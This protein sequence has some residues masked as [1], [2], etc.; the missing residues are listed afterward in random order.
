MDQPK[1][2]KSIKKINLGDAGGQAI[3]YN[4]AWVNLEETNS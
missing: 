1:E 4:K 3:G 2:T